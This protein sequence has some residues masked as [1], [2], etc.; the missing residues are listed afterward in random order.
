MIREARKQQ[1]IEAT[2]VTFDDIGYVK[3]S[4]AQIAKQASISTTLVSDHFT[5]RQDWINQ[6]IQA[7]LEQC[8]KLMLRNI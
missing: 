4:L 6:I 2:I 3:S 7:L 8:A 5:D 1:I